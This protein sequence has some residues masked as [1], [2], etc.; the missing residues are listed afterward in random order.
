MVSVPITRTDVNTV[1]PKRLR[2]PRLT[3]SLLVVEGLSSLFGFSGGIPLV[4]DSSGKLLGVP[5]S[6]LSSLPFRVDNFFWPGL[7]LLLVYGVGF[8]FTT[9][10]LW[11]GR[12]HAWSFALFLSLVWLG[13]I[14]FEMVFIG[15]SPLIALWYLP[16]GIA[17]A[18]LIAPDITHGSASFRPRP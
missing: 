5:V 8:A 3:T 17:L 16:Q 18:H 15:A 11:S 9:Y 6:V 4:L 1:K 2:R 12:P 7:W 14:T 13:W 10:L